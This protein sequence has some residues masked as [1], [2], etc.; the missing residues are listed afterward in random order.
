MS[1]PPLP[2][3]PGP[4]ETIPPFEPPL[5]S[6]GQ[7]AAAFAALTAIERG[8]WD[9]YLIRLNAAIKQRMRTEAWQRHIVVGGQP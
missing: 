6:E 8:E 5:P 2:R 9:R 4:D 3:I 7:Q 1:E